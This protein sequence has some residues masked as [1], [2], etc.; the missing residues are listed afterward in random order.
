MDGIKKASP[1]INNDFHDFFN[2][3]HINNRPEAII[4]PHKKRPTNKNPICDVIKPT[5]KIS[6]KTPP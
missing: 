5:E 4:N 3:P 2:K 1:L 6:I